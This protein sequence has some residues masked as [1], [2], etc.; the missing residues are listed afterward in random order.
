[1]GET[2][3]LALRL[4]ILG[5]HVLVACG[6][7]DGASGTTD[8]GTERRD[9][10]SL[11][12]DAG[13]S[14]GAPPDVNRPNGA[15]DLVITEIMFDPSAIA[16]E[17]GEW[18]ELHNP[19]RSTSWNLEGCVIGDATAMHQLDVGGAGLV[20][21]PGGYVTLAVSATPGF[22]PS[23]VYAGAFGLAGGAE[24]DTFRVTCGA[25]TIDEVV[26]GTSRG[27][28]SPMGASLSL[29]PSAIDPD[30][31]D[32]PSRWC[33]ATTEL[34]TGDLGSPGAANPAC[35]VGPRDAGPPP[36]RDSGPP[37]PDSGP[38]PPRDAGPP[39]GMQPSSAGAVVITEILYDPTAV[40]DADGEWFEIHNPSTTVAYD[41][42]GCVLED[43]TSMHT[44]G[45]PL[46][47]SPGAYVTLAR[48]ASSGISASYVYADAFGL[49]ND[50][51]GD[52]VRIGCG[53]TLIDEVVYS[54]AMGWPDPGGASLS[55]DPARADATSNDSPAS[56]CAASTPFSTGDL[57]TPGVA[58]P[59]CPLVTDAGPTDSGPTDSGPADSGPTDAGPTDA[60]PADSGPADSGS[61]V[62][63]PGAA[64]DLVISEILYD[65]E[66][67]TPEGDFEWI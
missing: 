44:I 19:S 40:G 63:L 67:M 42:S 35:P 55:L 64:G 24:G 32:D 36:P 20:V 27:F 11:R 17:L 2:N 58:N 57:G 10:G 8:M 25:E 53:G 5:V 39:T 22:A 43:G 31:N 7:D 28:P 26:Y 46:P 6:D 18:V 16:E 15:G 56:W 66:A 52:R 59:T 12:R 50:M 62:P 54:A 60:G 29:D 34:D 3:R 13:P 51:A 65:P 48:T 45:A 37:P 14:D 9:M 47:L 30:A 33:A 61:A 23:Y 4:T 49:N 38:P 41:L 1:M 21:G